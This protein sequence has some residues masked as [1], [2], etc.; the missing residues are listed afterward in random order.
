MTSLFGTTALLRFAVTGYAAAWGC[1]VFQ[2]ITGRRW[3]GVPA[4]LV[5]LAAWCANLLVVLFYGYEAGRPPLAGVGE[6]LPA[7]ACAVGGM[8][9]AVEVFWGMQT[10]GVVTSLAA[11]LLSATAWNGWTAERAAI[12]GEHPLCWLQALSWV[13]GAGAATAAFAANAILLFVMRKPGVDRET[14]DRLDKVVGY[15]MSVLALCFWTFG[16]TS[17]AAWAHLACGRYWSWAPRETWSLITWLLLALPA[18]GRFACGWK[19]RKPAAWSLAGFAA[20]AFT[21]WIA[22]R[23]IGDFQAFP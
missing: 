15:R 17:G 11:S 18:H 20:M 23:P 2:G 19:G 4:G 9:L 21:F 3:W 6:M 16:L 10:T 13:A 22:A 14:V 8:E 12:V 5:M 7:L 1:Y